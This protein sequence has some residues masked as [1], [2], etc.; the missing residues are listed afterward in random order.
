MS[1]TRRRCSYTCV[2]KA[3]GLDTPKT[4]GSSASLSR[5]LKRMADPQVLHTTFFQMEPLFSRCVTVVTRMRYIFFENYSSIFNSMFS[6]PAASGELPQGESEES[7]I[8]LEVLECSEFDCFLSIL[9]PSYATPLQ[10]L[11]QR[12]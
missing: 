8:V 2:F 1:K 3:L 12:R 5:R 4:E 6:L 9:Y 11:L 7:P 10:R